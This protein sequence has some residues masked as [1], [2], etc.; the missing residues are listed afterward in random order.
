MDLMNTQQ[1][2]T[3][4]M[5]PIYP[6]RAADQVAARTGARVLIRAHSVGGTEA[7]DTWFSMIDDLV[8]GLTESR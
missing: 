6:R 4:L 7:A 1:I 3:I 8:N 2:D 5:A